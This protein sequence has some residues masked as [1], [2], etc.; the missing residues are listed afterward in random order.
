MKFFLLNKIWFL[1]F[2]RR[3]LYVGEIDGIDASEI[4]LHHHHDDCKNELASLTRPLCWQWHFLIHWEPQKRG[5]NFLAHSGVHWWWSAWSSWFTSLFSGSWWEWWM[6]GMAALWSF[7]QAWALHMLLAA[8]LLYFVVGP[9]LW[10]LWRR[11]KAWWLG[12]NYEE[13]STTTLPS[14]YSDDQSGSGWSSYMTLRERMVNESTDLE[15]KTFLNPLL[16]NGTG[17]PSKSEC[18]K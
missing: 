6:S 11:L 13:W 14:F 3:T 15:D 10:Q 16:G 9:F 8:V 17:K 18:P 4:V 5:Q 7:L 2:S 1:I 12:R